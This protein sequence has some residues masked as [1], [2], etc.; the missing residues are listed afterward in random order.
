M[1][2]AMRPPQPLRSDHAHIDPPSHAAVAIY[3]DDGEAIDDPDDPDYREHAS[4]KGS[5]ALTYRGNDGAAAAAAT[6]ATTAATLVA[7]G[8]GV[9]DAA[10]EEDYIRVQ[11]L[12]GYTFC[13][14][15]EIR[16]FII[17]LLTGGFSCLL[18][19]WFPHRATPLR[20]RREP[21]LRRAEYAVVEAVDGG[22]EFVPVERVGPHPSAYVPRLMGKLWLGPR[23]LDD[24]EGHPD[25]YVPPAERMVLFRHH[26]FV[27][28]PE[29]RPAAFIKQCEPLQECAATLV[30][31]LERGLDPETHQS[32]QKSFGL[33]QLTIV[34]P[35]YPALLMRELF[36]PFFIF[37]IYSVIL[38]V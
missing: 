20:Y 33:N 30:E 15:K 38:S 23:H 1:A 24:P 29:A 27:L 11:S 3:T 31:R 26:R 5:Y 2:T 22:F 6:A 17:A 25:T 12:T 8:G 14:S 7:E 35:S 37:Q 36:H 16:Y 13:W 9:G 19:Y 21:D 10:A 18:A 32:R 28:D 4:R 34:V